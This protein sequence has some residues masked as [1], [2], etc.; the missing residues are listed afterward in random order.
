MEPRAYAALEAKLGYA[1]TRPDLLR[2]ALAHTSY[3]N[4]THGPHPE[5]VTRLAF[6]GD[7]VIELA[8]RDTVLAEFKNEPRGVLSH[9]ADKTV[10]DARLAQIA[11]PDGLDLGPWLALGG[12]LGEAGRS[13]PRVLADALEAVAGAIYLDCEEKGSAIAIVRALVHPVADAGPA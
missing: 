3:T 8:V 12:S 11:G 6:L 13:H 10:R 9:E 2:A 5:R 7:A 1:F 4:E